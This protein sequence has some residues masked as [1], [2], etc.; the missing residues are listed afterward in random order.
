MADEK[1]KS[2]ETK[3]SSDEEVVAVEHKAEGDQ[4]WMD[5][6]N[7]ALLHYRATGFNPGYVDPTRDQE[8]DIAPEFGV[9]PHPDLGNPAPPAASFSGRAL[10]PNSN[11]MVLSVEEKEERSAD[12]TEEFNRQLA[13]REE[14]LAN[15]RDTGFGGPAP[16]RVVI[17]DEDSEP[18]AGAPP[19]PQDESPKAHEQNPGD[20]LPQDLDAASGSDSD[21]E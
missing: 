17:V 11:P 6:Q 7:E 12:A 8:P 2:N 19:V 3:L 9:S 14:A 13:E 16:M 10:N 4:E 20:Q 18:A 1:N 5:N 21:E 15:L